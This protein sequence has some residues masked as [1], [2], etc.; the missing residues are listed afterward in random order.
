MDTKIHI[1]YNNAVDYKLEN[2]YYKHSF[3]NYD[4]KLANYLYRVNRSY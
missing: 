4:T 1:L 2:V 3:V